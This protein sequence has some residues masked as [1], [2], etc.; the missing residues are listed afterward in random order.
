MI[1]TNVKQMS[2]RPS[3]L[4]L[5]V[6]FVSFGATFVSGCES[7]VNSYCVSRCDCQGCSQRERA[8]CLDDVEDAERL[9]THDGCADAFAAYLQCYANEGSCTNGG[10][11]ASSCSDEGSALRACSD[12]SA[13]FVK[14]ACAEEKDKRE[15][16]GLTGGGA[17]PCAGADEC[18]AF[19]ALAAS[20]EDLANPPEDSTYVNCIVDCT[21]SKF[22]SGEP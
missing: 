21:S 8:D 2:L 6:G 20:C 10:W 9:S 17:D 16:C 7:Q 15:A 13:T 12:R 18:T 4:A 11:I 22:S 14:T 19:C 5:F 1:R 3:M